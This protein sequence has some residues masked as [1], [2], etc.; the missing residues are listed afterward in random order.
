MAFLGIE[1][2]DSMLAACNDK[3]LLFAE[4]G[5]AVIDGAAAVFG[6]EA[7]RTAYSRSVTYQDRYW[8]ALSEQVIARGAP[9]FESAA[10]L[11]YGQLGKL[12]QV[13]SPGI[14]QVAYA[15]PVYWS[16]EQL[17]LLLGISAELKIP[18]AALVEIPVAATRREYPDSELLHIEM[19]AHATTLSHM[20]QHGAAGIGRSEVFA[21]LG[22]NAVERSCAEYFARRFLACSRFDPLHSADSEQIVYEQLGSWLELLNRNAEAPLQFHFKGNEF[23]ATVSRAELVQSLQRR[24][25]PL[26]QSLRARLR[27]DRPTALQFNAAVARFPGLAE[28]FAELPGCDVF[29]LEPGAAAR[30]LAQRQAQLPQSTAALSLCASLPWDQPPAALSLER[31]MASPVAAK[32]SHVVFGSRAWRLDGLALR[33]GSEAVAGEYSLII[34]ARHA[35]ISR[36]HCSIETSNG[37]IVLHDHSRFGTRLNG[38]KVQ[39]SAVLQPGDVISLGDPVCELTLVAETEA[40]D[41][42]SANI[43]AVGNLSHGA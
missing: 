6:A 37:R 22:T 33:V 25:Q 5:C 32:P 18:V 41:V 38:H 27:V 30:G 11:A 35:G 19:S 20:T 4:P 40:A 3:Q 1:L 39:G 8:H 36:R 43:P 10:D 13:C 29:M 26:I 7:K 28:F 17:A 12:W 9:P 21:E 42:G 24:M 2:N 14:T 23:Q 15:V 31:A 16:K 34:D